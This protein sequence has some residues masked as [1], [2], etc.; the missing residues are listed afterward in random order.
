MNEM[1]DQHIDLNDRFDVF[2]YE[3]Y[4]AD[5]ACIIKVGEDTFCMSETPDA[6]IKQVY[7]PDP[8]TVATQTTYFPDTLTVS[9]Y[10]QF[11]K[12]W[13][14]PI[15]IWKEYNRDGLLVNEINHDEHYPVSW[16]E[17][18]KRF[19]ENGIHVNDIRQLRRLQNPN[20]GRYI[21]V[22]TLKSPHGVIDIAQFDAETGNLN[23]RKQTQI[24][25]S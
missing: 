14:I 15:G 5:G 21:W 8:I 19:L 25:V 18:Q 4:Y 3:R 10:G 22:L 17:M 20:T 1:L 2:T 7:P 6:Y 12:E 24:K 9:G 16:E 11:I 23:E 13:T